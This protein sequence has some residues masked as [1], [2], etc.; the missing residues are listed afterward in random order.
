MEVMN[1]VQTRAYKLNIEEQVLMIKNW[2]GSQGLQFIQ[3][4]TNSKKAF[5]THKDCLKCLVRNLNQ[6]KCLYYRYKTVN[7][8]GTMRKLHKSGWTDYE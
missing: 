3:I 7:Y 6:N 2:Q 5:K 1:E 4:F 8:G